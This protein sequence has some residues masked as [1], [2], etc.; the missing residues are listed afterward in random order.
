MYVCQGAFCIPTTARSRFVIPPRC[1]VCARALVAGDSSRDV[2]LLPTDRPTDRRATHTNDRNY[3]HTTTR[4]TMAGISRQPLLLLLVVLVTSSSFSLVAA[5][6]K[7]ATASSCRAT[8]PQCLAKKKTPKK[9]GSSAPTRGFGSA[10]AA[11]A[12]KKASTSQTPEEASWREFEAWL[13]KQGCMVD[14]V[15]LAD[16]GGGLRGVR[17]TRTVKAGEEPCANS[18]KNHPGR[19]TRRARRRGQLV[20]GEQRTARRVRQNR[21]QILYEKRLG[22]ASRSHHTSPSCP[23][24]TSSKASRP[25]P[26]GRTRSLP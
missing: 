14:A 23:R 19:G 7:A 3:T 16:C 17:T 11:A 26:R 12:K 5:P 10:P 24:R 1:T 25:Q 8:V 22:D 13:S 15:E 20:E 2:H 4:R 18:T 9:K 21:L 6:S